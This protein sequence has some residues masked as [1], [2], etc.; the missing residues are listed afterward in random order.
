MW[1]KL[2]AWILTAFTALANN[3]GFYQQ[4]VEHYAGNPGYEIQEDSVDY[5]ALHTWYSNLYDNNDSS[6]KVEAKHHN[7]VVAV[8]GVGYIIADA[9]L[10]PD[11]QLVF[12]DEN[13]I[14]APGKCTVMTEP[15]TSESKIVVQNN[16][17]GANGFK[18]VIENPKRWFCCES[19]TPS[20]SGQFY[21]RNETHQIELDQGD[22][23]CIAS[24]AT[25][26]TL[27]RGE[28][29]NGEL[30]KCDLRT[31]L[32]ATDGE[33]G[34]SSVN[35]DGNAEQ[36]VTNSQNGTDALCTAQIDSSLMFT[37]PSGWNNDGRWWW[38]RSGTAGVDYAANQYIVYGEMYYYFDSAG[39]M[40]TGW[41]NDGYYFFEDATAYDR[42]VS[43]FKQGAM[44]FN[45]VVPSPNGSYYVYVGNDGKI[46]TANDT[47]KPLQVG[48]V[49]YVYNNSIGGYEVSYAITSESGH[50]SGVDLGN[51]NGGQSISPQGSQGGSAAG[52]LT[53]E[54]LTDITVNGKFYSGKDGWYSCNGQ[55]VLIQSGAPAKPTAEGYL[56]G[57]IPVYAVSYNSKL[58][59]FYE[60][61]D[62]LVQ[63]SASGQSPT[64][65]RKDN[66]WYIINT[67]VGAIQSEWWQDGQ[68]R[69]LYA[70]NTGELYCKTLIGPGSVTG[71]YA[72]PS[73][74]PGRYYAFDENCY[75]NTTDSVVHASINGGTFEYYLDGQVEGSRS[76]R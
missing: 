37:G 23:I 27:Y 56:M 42:G 40:I 32:R 54:Q 18:M 44:C 21:H 33:T 68:G 51:N 50:S 17:K 63:G 8:S 12:S 69:W 34:D 70:G 26:V 30:K 60:D 7:T 13:I 41:N 4:P 55:W 39:Y 3:L 76:Q 53:L 16:G 11:A 2:I 64:Y 35:L 74:T 65:V 49:T 28:G 47:S 72:D 66:S 61:T 57:D 62:L 24:S 14:V 43:D 59:F 29:R 6:C 15:S 52:T 36:V 25:K 48:G 46:S 31:F 9:A 71:V 58:Y 1:S 75:L 20:A 67:D 38:G 22:T 10:N 5:G 45:T 73:G 19:S